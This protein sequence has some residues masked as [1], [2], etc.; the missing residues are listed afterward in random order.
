MSFFDKKEV[1]KDGAYYIGKMSNGERHGQGT[2]Y[3]ANGARYEGDLY[4]G[5]KHGYGK[6]RRIA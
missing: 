6:C 5:K 3:Y 1:Y 4:Y 2:Y